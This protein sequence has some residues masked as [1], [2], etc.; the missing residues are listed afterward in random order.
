LFTLPEKDDDN[1]GGEAVKPAESPKPEEEP[2]K[3]IQTM[4][5]E[6]HIELEQVNKTNQDNNIFLNSLL[7]SLHYQK[8]DFC[9]HLFSYII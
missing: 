2:P 3:E 6:E 8:E 7:S 4:D 9:N 1:G 5:L